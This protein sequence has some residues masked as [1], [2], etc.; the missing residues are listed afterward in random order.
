MGTYNYDDILGITFKLVNSPDYYEYDSEYDVWRD[1]T[2]DEAY[3]R[4]LVENSEDLTI[5]G[6]VQPADDASGLLLQACL[7]YTSRCV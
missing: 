1:K 4:S 5:V 7:L 2:D 3:M 6:I